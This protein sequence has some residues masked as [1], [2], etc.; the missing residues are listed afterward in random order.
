MKEILTM[1]MEPYTASPIGWRIHWE[2]R[3]EV[4]DVKTLGY[5]YL[6][7]LPFRRA[8]DRIKK[9][10]PKRNFGTDSGEK[11]FFVDQGVTP[12]QMTHINKTIQ[13]AYWQWVRSEMFA[14]R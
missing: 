13:K 5:V 3:P 10:F 9:R 8:I 12:A 14:A 11:Y 7:P 1:H 6:D 2:L 4:I